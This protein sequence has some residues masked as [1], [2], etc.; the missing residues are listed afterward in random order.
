[1][2]ADLIVGDIANVADAWL[3]G[4]DVYW[5]EG[6]PKERAASCLKYGLNGRSEDVT[7]PSFDART[8]VHEYGVAAVLVRVGTVHLP[9]FPIKNFIEKLWANHRKPQCRYA[10]TVFDAARRRL[11][12][13]REDHRVSESQPTNTIVAVTIDP[14]TCS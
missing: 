9:D 1:M 6:R 5:C 2:I 13:V 3:D 11:M 8:R 7:P 10:D 14:S 12:L 4:D